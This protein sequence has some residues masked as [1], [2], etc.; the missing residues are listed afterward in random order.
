VR[1]VPMPP[2]RRKSGPPASS[3]TE[4][5]LRKVVPVIPASE[6]ER[7]AL[8]ED[9]TSM[10]CA[11][12]FHKP[13]GFKE[14]RVIR[15]LV[16]ERPS[17]LDGTIRADPSKWT[18]KLWRDVYRIR[19]GGLGMAGRKDD[20]IRGKFRGTANPKDGFA[21]EDCIGNR[22]RRLLEF[23]LPIIHPEKPTRVTMTLGN[24]IFGSLSGERVGRPL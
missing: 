7:A 20:W 5:R 18:E 17:G 1:L 23:L 13:W 2:T 6:Q 12:F 22:N 21:L 3:P 10:G 9:L 11:E 15:E 19:S 24:T 8:M 4:V 14:E 16:G